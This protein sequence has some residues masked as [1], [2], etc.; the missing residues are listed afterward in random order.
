MNWSAIG[1]QLQRQSFC[2]LKNPDPEH[3]KSL[4]NFKAKSSRLEQSIFGQFCTLGSCTISDNCRQAELGYILLETLAYTFL[5]LIFQG[6]NGFY[7]KTNG[8]GFSPLDR[9]RKMPFSASKNKILKSICYLLSAGIAVYITQH[10]WAGC[11][12]VK[13]PNYNR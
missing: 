13:V 8:K 7:A 1:S 5:K 6:H 4:Q 12:G 3:Q 2:F 11:I 9:G 10:C